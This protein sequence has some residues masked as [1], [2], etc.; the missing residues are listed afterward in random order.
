VDP[1]P[2]ENNRLMHIHTN[3]EP[4]GAVTLSIGGTFNAA[5]VADFELALDAA[6]RLAQPVF[7]D[8]TRITLI[9]RP[10]LKYLIDLL[11]RDVRLVIC[12]PHVEQWIARESQ[13]D[14]AIE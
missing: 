11:H 5:G 2:K 14:E 13:T 12:P 7:L 3:I 6:R 10:T 8:L 9:D 4:S 1:F